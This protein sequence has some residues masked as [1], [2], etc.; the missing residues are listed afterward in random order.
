MSLSNELYLSLG[1]LQQEEKQNK[2]QTTLKT[3]PNIS[4]PQQTEF[5]AVLNCV[6]IVNE[7]MSHS[8]LKARAP[9]I[10]FSLACIFSGDFVRW[11]SPWQRIFGKGN[12]KGAYKVHVII[13]Y[14]VA[15]K[16]TNAIVLLAGAIL[17]RSVAAS[18]PWRGQGLNGA[19]SG[20]SQAGGEARLLSGELQDRRDEIGKSLQGVH[21]S[22]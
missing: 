5:K 11:K 20:C 13:V 1:C 4:Q 8:G 3:R 18:L 14:C 22:L 9:G 2:T 19:W 7:R 15:T 6:H 21:H 12:L 10:A 17:H 16:E